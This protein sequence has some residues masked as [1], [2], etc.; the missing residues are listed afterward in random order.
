PVGIDHLNPDP[1]RPLVVNILID[2]R[3]SDLRSQH[4]AI[5]WTIPSSPGSN[6]HRVSHIVTEIGFHHYTNW[7]PLTQNFDPEKWDTVP[8]GLLSREQRTNL[9]KIVSKTG[10]YLPN[11]EWNCQD[12]VI[13]VLDHAVVEKIFTAE[14]SRGAITTAQS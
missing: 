1:D 14:Q 10:V 13:K 3:L 11:G 12:W 5:S 4:W 7:G 6:I 2:R 8:I 9:E